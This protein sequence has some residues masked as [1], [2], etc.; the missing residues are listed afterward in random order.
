MKTQKVFGFILARLIVIIV[1]VASYV[2]L[3][4]PHVGPAPQLKIERTEARIK[5]REYPYNHISVCM[6]CHNTR[7]SSLF[8]AL[9]VGDFGGGGVKFTLMMDLPG[10]F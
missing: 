7:D 3:V 8:A 10:L 4:L 1:S 6:D 9:M 5:R 2:R